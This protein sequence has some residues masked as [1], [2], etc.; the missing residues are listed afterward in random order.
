MH[1]GHADFDILMELELAAALRD[2]D[3]ADLTGPIENILE[4]M[5]MNGA[6]MF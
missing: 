5:A 2:L 3:G 6:E 4:K 1:V